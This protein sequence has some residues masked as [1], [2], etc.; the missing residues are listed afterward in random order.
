MRQP[1]LAPMQP[2]ARSKEDK[3]RFLENLGSLG[4]SATKGGRFL[5]LSFG[6]TKA[7][8]MAEIMARYSGSVSIALGD[9]PN[10]V[11]MIKAA[12]YGVIVANPG[13]A[14][15]PTLP[16]EKGGRIIRTKKPGPEGWS[17][18]VMRILSDLGI[19]E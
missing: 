6:A 1:A 13:H 10:D 14:P 8:R 17:E 2:T 18:A 7:D 12:D 11:E 16:G 3:V 15:L 9:A 5:T 4:I 19:T